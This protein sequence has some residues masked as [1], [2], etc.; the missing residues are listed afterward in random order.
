MSHPAS[1]IE[2]WHLVGDADLEK[3]ENALFYFKWL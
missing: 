2:M 1:A 3:K